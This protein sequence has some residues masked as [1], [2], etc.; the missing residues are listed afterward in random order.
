[1]SPARIWRL[2]G[3]GLVA[4]LLVA[5]LAAAL[6]SFGSGTRAGKS[7]LADFVSRAASSEG[8]KV[9]V[10][11]IEG[12]LSSRPLLRDI[13]I[14]DK[15]G[16][17]LKVDRIE[18]DWSRL[19][20]AALRVDID[21]IAIGRVDVLRRPIAAP[22][23]AA[24]TPEPAKKTGE[25][26]APDL[27]V[28]FR[29]G[30]LEI[31]TLALAAPVL[32]EPATLTLRA[33]AEAGASSDGAKA[34][35]SARR[36]DAPGSVDIKAEISPR[37]NRLALALSAREPAGGVIARLA[38]LPG[39]PPIDVA[40]DGEGPLDKFVAKLV[41]KA[42]EELGA[43]GDA[44]LTAVPGGRR[45]EFDVS[46]QFAPLLPRALADIFAGAT[47]LKGGALLGGNGDMALDSLELTAS[48][49]RL[50]ASGRL[51]PDDKIEARAVM[52]GLPASET[53]AFRAKTLEGELTV[54]GSVTR[55]DATLRLLVEDALSS[56]GRFG[57][58][59]AEVKATPDGPPAG[60]ARFDI[61]ARAR[62]DEL[63]FADRGLAD[64]LGDRATLNLRA[65]ASGGGD[66]DI[67]LAKVETAT[68]AVSYSGK[69]G[70]AALQGE[71]TATA[72]LSR[73]ARLAGRDLRGALSLTAAFAGAP[74]EGKIKAVINGAVNA[75]GVGVAAIDGLMGRKLALIGTV[76]SLA[77]GGLSLDALTAN[78][79]FAQMRVNGA[80]SS[81]KA[82][83]VA[84]LALPDLRHADSRMTGRGD[85]EAKIS[86]SLQ[87]PEAALDA[88]LVDASANGRAIPKLALHA[89]G[90]DL[91]GA[92]KASAALDGTVDGR[93]ARGRLEAS[94]AGAGWKLDAVD[95]AIGRAN[96]KGSAIYASAINGRLALSAPDLD[97]LSALALQKLSGALT[98]D[99]A[100]D[101]AS[102]AQNATI[103][104]NGS[105]IRARELG[106]ERLSAKLS[107]R[108]LLRRPALD[109]VATLENLRV[110][111][112]LVSSATVR[113]RPAGVATAL[114]LAINARGFAIAGAATLT[115][116]EHARVDLSALTIQRGGQRIALAGP[117]SVSLGGGE[118]ELKGV[119]V[120][121]GAGRLDLAGKVGDHLDLTARARAV[122]LAIAAIVNSSLGLGGSL[123][124]DAHLTGSKSAP[125]GDWKVA[126]SKVTAPQ[127]RASGLPPLDGS[128]HGQ[129][130][131]NRTSV[132]AE[133]LMGKTSHVNVKGSAPLGAT[134]GL[135]L[136]VKGALDAALANTML[137]ADG[138]TLRGVA[139]LDLKLVGSATAPIVGGGVTFSDGA[140]AD[141]VNGLAF[142]NM[143]ARLEARG[144]EMSIASM[145][146][147]TGNGGQIAATGRVSLL[148][149][150]GFPGAIHIASRNARLVSSDLV[151]ATADLDLN[152]AGPLARAPKISGAVTFNTLEVNV[153]DRLPASLKPLPDTKHLD[154][155]SFARE[156]LALQGKR[157]AAAAR[158]SS[159]AAALDLK[160]SAPNR[161][162][163][164]GRGIDAEFG[165]DLRIAGAMQK[166]VVTGAFDLRRGRLQLPTQRIDITRGKLTFAGGLT[167]ELDFYAETTA[168]DVT[169]RIA[170][171]GPAAQPSFAFTS[172]PELPQDEVLSRLLFG[173]A[174]GTLSPLQAVQLA[175]SVAQ[176]SGV[177]SGGGGFEKMRKALGVD[178]L[179][180]D[181]GGAGGPTVG[182]STYLTDN[183]NVGVRA[184]AKP[185]DAAVN[186][187]LDVTKKLRVQS[188]T[189]MD[190][191]TSVGVGV[192]W[193]Y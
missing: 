169:A 147:T 21:R 5:A 82:D 152:L 178:S 158:P 188:E 29:L 130:A 177:D 154:P 166:P 7:M 94:R 14:A 58:F 69:A 186:V 50:D 92:L 38:R 22:A 84:R 88:V 40:L 56:A 140:F 120:N 3:L 68:A 32:G 78:G 115:P 180:L 150:A 131:G 174:S 175:T 119:S 126:L 85:V 8:M 61:S 109:G 191:H 183:V 157:T 12:P 64:A 112:E 47:R 89:L 138:Q 73:F 45:L 137:S 6:L 35:F 4:A 104:M 102:G 151:S 79:E 25:D 179:D 55:P 129:L 105:G 90:R 30:A 192:E 153:P 42:G 86:G 57:H 185:A 66:V 101:G 103:D 26:V 48:A 17:W 95:L 163:V 182:A 149:E 164:R 75:P 106:V 83:I 65:R 44:T 143:S 165:G 16:V 77:G 108:D 111:K 171:S 41:A 71:M 31:E 27:P 63:A 97:D 124:L 54:A 10:G 59:D 142:K 176:L 13:A 172:V 11:E 122:P 135:D 81:E 190:G 62:G 19:P 117:A 96:L 144:R 167:P 136:S 161:I 100:L 2:A 127:L 107:G 74:R 155:K 160:I 93:A 51:G 80:A 24:A 193:E 118:A 133:I 170:V 114:D 18:M 37:P 53:A 46:S 141:P 15:D 9:D 121:L 76:A 20:L 128:A 116:G 99:I 148:P 49:L 145:T 156:M 87:K 91:L 98:A 168:G 70:P 33:S 60:E 23:K 52:H 39:L 139:N 146:A 43:R 110:G 134:G 1:M 34:T 36:G 72:D 181:A 125:A 189:R 113:A 173:K 67:G 184:G 132:D 28:R 187:G 159:F 123:E 162:F